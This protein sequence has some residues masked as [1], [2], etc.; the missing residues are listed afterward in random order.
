MMKM[1]EKHP[2]FYAAISQSPR[3]WFYSFR[4]FGVVN[5]FPLHDNEVYNLELTLY[6]T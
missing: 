2:S 5:A 4:P 1:R 6:R 3:E